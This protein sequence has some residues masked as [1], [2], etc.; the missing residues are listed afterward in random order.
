MLRRL[1]PLLVAAVLAAGCGSAGPP[2]VT[3]E[4]GPVSVQAGPTQYCNDEFT[5]CRND[6]AAP[7]EMVVPPGTALKVS[8]PSEIAETPWHLVFRYRDAAGAETDG[9]SPVL[10]QQDDYALELPTPTDRLITAEV[11]QFGPPPQANPDTGEIEF[12]IRAS[13]VLRAAA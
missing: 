8:V 12:P 1:L 7:V 6:A 10:S 13:W 5:D 4:A 3:F 9:R 2:R 11:Q